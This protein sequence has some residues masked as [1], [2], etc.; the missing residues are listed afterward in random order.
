MSR[1]PAVCLRELPYTHAASPPAAHLAPTSQPLARQDLGVAE[2][3]AKLMELLQSGKAG[4]EEI[5]RMSSS[6]MVEDYIRSV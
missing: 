2:Y 6:D 4:M 3:Q 5:D 1:R